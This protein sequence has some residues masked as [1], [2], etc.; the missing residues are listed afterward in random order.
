[1]YCPKCGEK[2]IS[3]NQE[4]CQACG[5]N[6]K[7][8]IPNRRLIEKQEQRYE[9]KDSNKY[10]KLCFSFAIISFIEAQVSGILSFLLF[11]MPLLIIFFLILN[12]TGIIFGC[13]S[14]LFKGK[15]EEIEAVTTLR[16]V[17]SVFAIIGLINNP[18]ILIETIFLPFI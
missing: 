15:S 1:M 4:F 16:K 14:R 2:L 10:A 6:L 7:E 8:L 5:A 12:I 18:I 3:P 9:L 13:L 11:T 17:G